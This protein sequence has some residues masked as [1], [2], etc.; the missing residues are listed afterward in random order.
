M[1]SLDAM[2]VNASFLAQGEGGLG[3]WKEVE[4]AKG[5]IPTRDL[6][7]RLPNALVAS[8]CALVY[9]MEE[10]VRGGTLAGCAAR[11]IDDVAIL[12]LGEAPSSD[13]LSL[14]RA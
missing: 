7:S 6:D 12:I 10:A 9:C 3:M 14:W 5:V 4:Q 11:A 1:Y 13:H 2:V 8:P